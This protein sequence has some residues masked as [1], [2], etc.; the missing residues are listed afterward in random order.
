MHKGLPADAD[1][2]REKENSGYRVTTDTAA[3][4]R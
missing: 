3:P 1:S 2:P 4:L